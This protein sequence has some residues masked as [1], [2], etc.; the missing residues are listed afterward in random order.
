MLLRYNILCTETQYSGP[1][2][3]ISVNCSRHKFL[4]ASKPGLVS[5]VDYEYVPE[6]CVWELTLRCNMRCI[7]CGSSAGKSRQNELTID[8]CLKVADDLLDMGCQHVTFIGGEVFLY[9]GW[10]KVARRFYERGAGANIITNAF[11]FGKDQIDQIKYAHLTNVGISLDG[12]EENHN[13]I[14]N[15]S[16][17]FKRVLKAFQMLREESI[18]VG[19]VTSL[20]NINYHDL[21]RLYSLLVENQVSVWQIQLATAMGNM[22]DQRNLL[23]D[24]ARIPEI[25][26]FIR[27]KRGLQ[28]M[29]VYAGDDI[30]YYDEN[31]MYLRGSP[32]TISVWRGCQAGLKA[33]GI[34]SIGNVKGCESLYSDEFV[35]GNLREE[36]VKEIWCKEGGFAYNRKFNVNQLKG[37]C[38]DCDKGS[39]CRGGCRGSSYFTTGSYYE[40]TYCCYPRKKALMV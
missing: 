14:R 36:S 32:G 9:N 22:G 4:L 6:A 19:V 3:S 28:E 21:E 31:E 15:N 2:N 33:I 7:H 5:S 34:D 35:E 38:S 23:L 10:E 27:K 12:I 13:R 39:L 17:S 26:E 29:N 40:N 1:K 25:T 8:E 24:P 37:E 30:G 16:E 20:M 18:P 11:L